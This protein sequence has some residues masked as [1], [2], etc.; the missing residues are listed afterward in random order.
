MPDGRA[1]GGGTVAGGGGG[2]RGGPGALGLSGHAGR[3]VTPADRPARSAP[4]TDCHQSEP[5][6]RPVD[7]SA[8]SA[9]GGRRP[10]DDARLILFR[11]AVI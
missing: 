8:L 2:A 1:G 9:G 10:P 4:G 3:Q 5:G 11:F 7:Q 6:W